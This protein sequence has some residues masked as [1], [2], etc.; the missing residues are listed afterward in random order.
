MLARSFPG[1]HSASFSICSGPTGLQMV[2][3]WWTEP[4][5]INKSDRGKFW[6]ISSSQVTV[7]CINST[8]KVMAVHSYIHLD[9]KG[10]FVC[11]NKTIC[12]KLNPGPCT[13]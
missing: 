13:G 1:L 5:D 8:E 10:I 11:F 2:L 3:S 4:S 7:V 6:D 9:F 12:Q